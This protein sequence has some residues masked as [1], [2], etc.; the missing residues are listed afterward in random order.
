VVADVQPALALI[1]VTARAGDTGAYRQKINK[2]GLLPIKE[3]GTLP[4]LVEELSG[5][6]H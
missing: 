1:A 5:A 6:T 4:R 2:V 3:K